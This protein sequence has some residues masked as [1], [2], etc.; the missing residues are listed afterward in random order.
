MG[1]RETNF[2]LPNTLRASLVDVYRRLRDDLGRVSC[3]LLL[4]LTLVTDN[5]H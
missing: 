2:V 1:R 3:L 5:C 4:H